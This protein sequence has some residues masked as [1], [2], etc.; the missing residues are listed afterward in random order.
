MVSED[1]HGRAYVR[2]GTPDSRGRRTVR[3]Y[4][5]PTHRDGE[6]YDASD[7]TVDPL[8]GA[9]EMWTETIIDRN[10]MVRIKRQMG[11]AP[12]SPSMWFVSVDDSRATGLDTRSLVA[13]DTDHFPDGTIIDE[14]EFVLL[15]VTNEQQIAAIQWR[16]STGTVEQIYVTPDARRQDIGRRMGHAA[17]QFHQL[18]DWSGVVRASGRRTVLGQQFTVGQILPSRVTEHTELS[19]PMDQ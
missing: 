1:F 3:T 16:T 17:G 8:S 13:F 12:D 11:Q 5:V 15:P 14:M 19:P 9:Y 6:K 4:A 2:F 7:I 10:G 18:N